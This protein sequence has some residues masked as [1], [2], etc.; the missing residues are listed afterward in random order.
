MGQMNSRHLY[1]FTVIAETGSFTAAA[2]KLG[3]SQ[4]PLSKQIMMLE[5]DLGVR[6][7]NRGARKAELTEAGAYLYSRA[8]DILSMMDTAA[9]ELQNF[10]SSAK[11]ILKLERSPPPETIWQTASFRASAAFIRM[12]ASKFP[13]GTPMSFWRS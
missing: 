10:P 8:R 9:S 7:L 12:S 1:Y 13:R 4:P 11:G 2:K 5:E 3:L 6:L